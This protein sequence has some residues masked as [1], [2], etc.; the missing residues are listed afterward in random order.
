MAHYT[1]KAN[2]QLLSLT[3][4]RLAQLLINRGFALHN[5]PPINNPPQQAEEIPQQAEENPQQAQ[6]NSQQFEENSQQA[7]EN[8]QSA[9]ETPQLSTENL[10][11]TPTFNEAEPSTTMVHIP[12]DDSDDNTPISTLKRKKQQEAATP[13]KRKP[14]ALVSHNLP[15]LRKSA[16]KRKAIVFPASLPRDGQGRP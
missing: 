7:A 14:R 1:V 5:P 12:T 6:E 9:A 11:Q 2:H 16:R 8:Q 4:H 10:Q 15:I 3:H 13:L